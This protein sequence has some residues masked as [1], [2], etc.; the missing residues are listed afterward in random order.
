MSVI[1]GVGG[2]VLSYLS[3]GAGYG[4]SDGILTTLDAKIKYMIVS[5]LSTE[6]N[7]NEEARKKIFKNLMRAVNYRSRRFSQCELTDI[8][9]SIAFCVD[10]KEVKGYWID[11]QSVMPTFLKPSEENNREESVYD[12]Y[13]CPIDRI[14]Y[15]FYAEYLLEVALD[16]TV[17]ITLGNDEGDQKWYKKFKRI[18]DKKN[19]IFWWREKP[20]YTSA[21]YTAWRKMWE[22]EQYVNIKE[23][24][25]CQIFAFPIVT[26]KLPDGNWKVTNTLT[27]RELEIRLPYY[28]DLWKKYLVWNKKYGDKMQ[29]ELDK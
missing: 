3:E 23:R 22:N 29:K 12:R 28:N 25:P 11:H 10:W 27:G 18:R 20:D 8:N 26:N 1:H 4:R 5:L 19:K 14:D 15:N 7:G 24:S 2:N 16:P 21:E 9:E 6:P 17:V 13:E